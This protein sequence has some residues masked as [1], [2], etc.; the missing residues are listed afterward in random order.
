MTPDTPSASPHA[1]MV[2]PA[3]DVQSLASWFEAELGFVLTALIPADDPAIACL[4]GHGL[5]IRLD[6]HANI[7]PGQIHLTRND[8]TESST[9]TAPNGTMIEQMIADSCAETS[10]LGHSFS[11]IVSAYQDGESFVQGRAGMRYRDLIP[12]RLADQVIA[13]HI[14]IV[15][16]GPVNDRVHY[17]QIGAQMILCLAGWVRVVYEH[18]GEPFT[19]RA[20]DAVLQP[21]GIR[22]RVLSAS[23]GLDVLEVGTP[24][25]H[26]THFDPDTELPNTPVD[27]N[28]LWSNQRF[29]H[30]QQDQANWSDVGLPG[31]QIADSGIGSASGGL[32]Q[33]NVIRQAPE[34]HKDLI[35]NAPDDAVTLLYAGTGSGSLTISGDKRRGWHKHD[36]CTIPAATCI[37]ITPDKDDLLTLYQVCL[38]ASKES[39]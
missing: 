18:Q 35:L 20:G 28:H 24:A 34:L 27:T 11:P 2:L 25:N 19:M 8:I 32:I 10:P 39:P 9:L 21:P 30:F 17:H 33:L 16:G 4:R 38:H 37:R 31:Y 7:S 5:S 29:I 13:S 22:H 6:R 23:A 36:A 1:E 26:W 15:E 14:R 12:C 3:D